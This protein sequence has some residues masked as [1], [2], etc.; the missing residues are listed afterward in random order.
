[1]EIQI[2]QHTLEAA[3]RRGTEDEIRMYSIQV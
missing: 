3:Q 1:M 2:D